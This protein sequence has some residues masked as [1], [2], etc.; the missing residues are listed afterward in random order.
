MSFNS[1]MTFPIQLAD[2]EPAARDLMSHF[3]NRGFEVSGERTITGD[4]DVSISQ[5]GLFKAIAG[6]KTALKI[7]ISSSGAGTSVDAG[8][9][10]FGQQA[11]PT[12][13]SLLIFWPLLIT[14]VWGLIE[15]S[16][17]DDEAV[18]VVGESLTR[19]AGLAAM[20][21]A[22][23][24]PAPVAAAGQSSAGFCT[25]CAAPLTAG[26]RFCAQCAAPVEAEAATSA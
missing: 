13:I 18:R 4:W 16:K 21:A 25:N 11:I 26:A 2:L 5:Q 19:H 7:R 20:P 8:V 14:Q 9:G 1:K 24:Q 23:A 3:V 22:A 12:A 6:L 15:Q 10:I 17:L